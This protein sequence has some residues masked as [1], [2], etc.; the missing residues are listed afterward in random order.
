VRPQEIESCIVC[1]NVDC[2]GLGSE[3]I[4]EE[5]AARLA[6][7]GST[8]VVRPYIC[9]GACRNAPNV[10]L[11]PEGTWYAEVTADDVDDIV[12]HVCGGQPV[13]RLMNRVDPALQ[14]LILG[15]IDAGLGQFAEP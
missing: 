15:V 5:I 7:A 14:R 4:G 8:V 3:A 9:F 1:H 12:A 13:E 11:Y 6:A 2:A 10:V